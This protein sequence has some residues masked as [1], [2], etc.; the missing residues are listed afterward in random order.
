[1]KK[2]ALLISLAAIIAVPQLYLLADDMGGQAPMM[3]S[4]TSGAP[5]EQ[6]QAPKKK[7][8]HHKK[9]HKK[10]KAA[11]PAAA[12]ANAEPASDQMIPAK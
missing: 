5:A 1:M 9:K 4:D 6:T 10:K 2:L 12:P 8:K 11:A 3:N 7:K